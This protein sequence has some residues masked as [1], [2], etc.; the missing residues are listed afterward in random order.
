MNVR[1]IVTGVCV[2]GIV[3]GI[4][5]AFW[6]DKHPRPSRS[7]SSLTPSGSAGS[8]SAWTPPQLAAGSGSAGSGSAAT[9]SGSAGSGAAG[10]GSASGRVVTMHAR[11]RA[12]LTWFDITTTGTA[13]PE[14]CARLA[15]RYLVAP[16]PSVTPKLVRGCEEAGLPSIGHGRAFELVLAEPTED[17]LAAVPNASTTVAWVDQIATFEGAADCEA[18]RAAITKLAA[19]AGPAPAAQLKTVLDG[20]AAKA[21][22]DVDRACT[23]PTAPGCELAAQKYLIIQDSAARQ[24]AKPAVAPPPPPACHAA[25]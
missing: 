24:A 10:S 18:A 14:V 1:T 13:A 25:H 19:D 3:A 8:G 16:L 11:V 5:Y 21:K 12:A 20:L 17:V 7:L 22:Q 2:A 9:G 23:S 4:G 15:E 6:Y